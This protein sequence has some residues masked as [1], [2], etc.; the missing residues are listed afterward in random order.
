MIL[1]MAITVGQGLSLIWIIKFIPPFNWVA[2]MLFSFVA[3]SVQLLMFWIL[4]KIMKPLSNKP[5]FVK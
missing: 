2:D 1:A 4:Y 5:L 3:F